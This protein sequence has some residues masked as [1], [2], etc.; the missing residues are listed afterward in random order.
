LVILGGG[1]TGTGG[2]GAGRYPA[3]FPSDPF[4]GAQYRFYSPNFMVE[5]LEGE[6]LK[7]AIRKQA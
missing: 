1:A 4:Y 6:A 2:A 5:P 3:P 7:D